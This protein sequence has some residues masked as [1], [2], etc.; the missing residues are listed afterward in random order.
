MK[1]LYKKY[2]YEENEGTSNRNQNG[3]DIPIFTNETEFDG[4]STED[5]AEEIN[6]LQTEESSFNFTIEEKVILGK[7]FLG[8]VESIIM[9]NLNIS[10]K[11]FSSI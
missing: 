6:K 9:I 4:V 3:E 8:T 5:H 10:L 2:F 7:R 1:R 11:Y